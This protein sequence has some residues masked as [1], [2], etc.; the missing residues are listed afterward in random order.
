M[1]SSFDVWSFV[2]GIATTAVTV[3][4]VFWWSWRQMSARHRAEVDALAERQAAEEA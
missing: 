1:W 3:H 2:A 4:A